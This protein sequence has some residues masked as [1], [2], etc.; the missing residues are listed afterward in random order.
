MKHYRQIFYALIGVLVLTFGILVFLVY[1]SGVEGRERYKM[2]AESLLKFTAE[3]WVHQEFEKLGIPYSSSGGEPVVE[4]RIRRM[5]FAK[6]TIAVE[7]DS[8]KEAKLLFTSWAL[9]ARS[10]FI[11]LL[12]DSSI[13]VLG[14]QW[15]ESLHEMKFPDGCVLELFNEQPDENKQKRIV[16][17]DSILI[18]EA[19]IL[20]EY[21]LDNM[22]FFRLVSYLSVPSIWKCADWGETGIVL[23]YIVIALV[24][25]TIVSLLLYNLKKERGPRPS[26]LNNIVTCMGEGKYK[27]GDLVFDEKERTL[28]FNDST[29]TNLSAQPYKLLSSLIHTE[30][31]FLSY[32]Q[33]TTI[34]GWNAGDEGLG[35]KRRMSF[36]NLRKLLDIK[37]SHVSLVSEKEKGVYLTIVD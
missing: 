8:V 16:A 35:D 7:V 21:Y 33:V 28:T 23:C 27:I 5:V 36:N 12:K 11:L 6:D 3:L 15:Q 9:N 14:R 32:E 18:S 13:C 1:Q 10:K 25:L 24:F 37:K 4:S 30:N 19:N 31:C 34:C 22:Y 17:G 26:A 2:K 20:D 29:I